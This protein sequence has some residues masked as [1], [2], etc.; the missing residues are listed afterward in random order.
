MVGTS[1]G[2]IPLCDGSLSLPV[3]VELQRSAPALGRCGRRRGIRGVE[4]EFTCR[5]AART[6]TL[7]RRSTCPW[8]PA[9]NT[10]VANPFYG[11]VKDRDAVPADRAAGPT[12]AAVPAVHGRFRRRRICRQL[13]LSR[14]ADEGGARFSHGGTVLAA[15]TFS[16]LLGDVASRTGWLDSGVGAAPGAQNPYD[17]R[18]EKSLAGFRFA[19]APGCQLCRG[20]ADRQG[21]E[22]PQ[23]RQRASCRNSLPVGA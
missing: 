9:L 20:S 15:Y 12:A 22:I 2:N 7:S 6:R 3:A 18:A 19:P 23:R 11:M 17:L 13:H 5:A 1:L 10:Q 8:A 21:P 14:I 4:A 16:K